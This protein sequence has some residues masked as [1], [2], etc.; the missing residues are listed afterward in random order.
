M[1]ERMAGKM[2][3]ILHDVAR[4]ATCVSYVVFR[5]FNKNLTTF[6]PALALLLAFEKLAMAFATLS[7]R[8]MAICRDSSEIPLQGFDLLVFPLEVKTV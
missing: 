2:R 8:H 5:K 6:D 4:S 7:N 1:A 3:T